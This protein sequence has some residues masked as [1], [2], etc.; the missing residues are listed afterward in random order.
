LSWSPVPE[1][2]VRGELQG[3]KIQTWSEKYGEEGIRE[4]DIRGGNKTHA[5]ITTFVPYSK[6]FARIFAYN[7]R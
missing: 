2:T 1:E 6:T 5:L 7:G 4:I 3:Y